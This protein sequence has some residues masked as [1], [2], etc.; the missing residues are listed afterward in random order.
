MDEATFWKIIEAAGA[1]DRCPPDEQCER[2]TI[3][4]A[5]LPQEDLIAFEN[6][7]NRLLEKSYTWPMLKACFV[8]LSYVSDDVFED[9]Q[10]WII[11][12]GR[13]RFEETIKNPDVIADYADV[14]DPVEEISGEPLMFVVEAAFDGEIEDLE[15]KFDYPD[16]PDVA[17]EWPPQEELQ[18]EFPKLFERFWNE[19]RIREI[20]GES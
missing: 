12:H 18:T 16:L 4:L 17:D 3:A 9:F 19:D 14:E 20:H 8:T 1:P 5:Q 15:D 6:L 11:L 10:N 13:Q 2:I 7:R